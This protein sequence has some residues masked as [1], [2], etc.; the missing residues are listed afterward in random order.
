MAK[1]R[2]LLSVNTYNRFGGGAYFPK[3]WEHIEK[4]V[5]EPYRDMLDVAVYDDGSTDEGMG[6]YLVG[7]KKSGRVDWLT[8][9]PDRNPLLP[10]ARHAFGN[11]GYAYSLSGWPEHEFILHFDTDIWF[12]RPE[13]DRGFD[14]LNTCIDRLRG[15]EA[16]FA[17]SLWGCLWSNGASYRDDRPPSWFHLRWEDP[18][19]VESSFFSTRMF[20]ARSNELAENS[21]AALTEVGR[22]GWTRN[23]RRSL[24]G[25]I[26]SYERLVNKN[27][28]YAKRRHAAFL[29]QESGVV[30]LHIN[31]LKDLAW[32]KRRLGVRS[33]ADIKR[34]R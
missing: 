17:T 10:L 26:D 12:V 23:N 29:R 2:V 31:W 28:I 5:V 13:E 30:T 25:R 21:V 7:L 14:W 15:S 19:W 22:P 34:I 3:W 4:M 33:E 16:T 1:P 8:L 6:D 9:G 27:E 11:V 20:L 18:S 24:I 32:A